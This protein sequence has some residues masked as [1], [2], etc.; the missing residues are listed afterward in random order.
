MWSP[1]KIEIKNLFSHVDSSY[2]FKN[3]KCTV[4]FGENK[5][6]K[7]FE[8]NGA[9]KTTMF[10]GICIALTGGSLRN[11]QKE[12][13]INRD[14]ESSEIR[15]ELENKVLKSTLVI[16]RKFYRGKSSQVELVENGVV[17]K[18]I[19]SVNEAN[20]RILELIGVTREDLLRYYIVGQDNNYR[21]FTASDADKKEIL[22][23]IT[24]ADIL[25]PVLSAIDADRKQR[26]TEY[27]ETVMERERV[28]A[29]I[30]TLQEQK[31]DMLENSTVEEEISQLRDR[32]KSTELTIKEDR[33]R[34]VGCEKEIGVI[35][36][37]LSSMSKQDVAVLRKSRKDVR[38][39]LDE[40]DGRISENT[41]MRKKIQLE[42][43]GAVTCPECGAE[44]IQ[45]SELGISPKEAKQLLEQLD[46]ESDATSKKRG[47]LKSKVAELTTKIQEADERNEEIAELE[48]SV[49]EKQ[50]RIAELKNSITLKQERIGGI[51]K[52]IQNLQ[53]DSKNDVKI[54]NLEKKIRELV[55][56]RQEIS[57]LVAQKEKQLEMCKFWKFNMGKSGFATYLANKSVKVIEGIT[58]SY[59]RKFGVE[60]SV[61]INGF[62]VLKSG[63]VR[64]KIDCFVTNDGV[65]ME[66]FM[67]KSGGERGRV[68][69]AGI[70]GIQRLLNESSNGRGLDLLVL[71]EAFGG[72]DRLGTMEFI[73]T[74]N[75]VGTT[76]MVVTQ[77]VEDCSI[78][79]NVLKVVKKDGVSRYI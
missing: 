19:V 59:L 26:E 24:Q 2:T 61:L 77:N 57:I 6:D 8:N 65:T 28:D 63:E 75:N 32:I 37:K 64:E 9:G 78:Y 4:V 51:E 36:V 34:I 42:L 73:N 44:F 14:S 48:G 69:V 38:D 49:R 27:D 70:L 13:F 1:I 35:K 54:K 22:N 39:E 46:K 45:E 30:E 17:N 7:S 58:N 40:L 66:T 53:N 20:S 55:Q 72:V 74:L 52:Q 12:Q 43:D 76:I 29:Q 3:G 10:E 71:D 67:A 5:T 11:L 62:T 25:N 41:A 47:K 56:H 79:D 21:F 33:G 23:R 31:R 15:F 16:T 50:G 68:T 60:M 18:Q